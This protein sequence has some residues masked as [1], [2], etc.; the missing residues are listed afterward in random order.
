MTI[1]SIIK[2][3]GIT[4]LLHFTT[5]NGVVGSLAKG[6]VLSRHRLPQDQYLEHILRVN[7]VTRP[8]ESESFDKSKNWLDYVNLSIS[9]INSRYF[10]VSNKWH[11]SKDLW[12]AIL[13]FDSVL[14][15]HSDVVFATTNNS[16]DQ[17]LRKDGAQGLERLFSDV[18][19]RKSPNWSVSRGGRAPN[20]PTCEQAEVLYPGA[21]SCSFLR[22]IY[23]QDNMSHDVASGWL[24]E[25]GIKDVSVVISRAKFTGK[26]N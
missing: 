7:A 11:Q 19:R 17:C 9:E 15:T 10:G 24:A 23:V 1:S 16:Y 25:F 21:V 26:P 12:W 2:N 14:M 8:E 20:L 3:R 22:R 5:N 13:A 18:I 4:E 6:A